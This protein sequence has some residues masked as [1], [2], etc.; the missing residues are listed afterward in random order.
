MTPAPYDDGPAY[1]FDE[2]HYSIVREPCFGGCGRNRTSM[3]EAPDLQSGGPTTL[4]NAS[5]HFS[6]SDGSRTRSSDLASRRAASCTS[7]A[8]NRVPLW[9]HLSCSSIGCSPFG[10]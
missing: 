9:A 2:I 8:F 6:A 10:P 4:P 7:P 3:A 1:Y 5:I